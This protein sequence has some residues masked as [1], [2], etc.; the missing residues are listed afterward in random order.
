MPTAAGLKEFL[1][2]MD[3]EPH[4][5]LHHALAVCLKGSETSADIEL[6]A[7]ASACT[8]DQTQARARDAGVLCA[9][10]DLFSMGM[11]LMDEGLNPSVAL[12][13]PQDHREIVARMAQLADARRQ[14]QGSCEST[15]LEAGC[16]PGLRADD[17]AGPNRMT[18]KELGIETFEA[19]AP[20][21]SAERALS[22][23][24]P[25]KSESA[26]QRRPTPPQTQPS[27]DPGEHKSWETLRL[28]GNTAA[29]TLE[30][31]SHRRAGNFLGVGVVSIESARATKEGFDWSNKLTFQLTPEEMPEIIAVL[32][33]IRQKATF[34]NHGTDRNKGLS[35]RNQD[36][37]LQVV[38]TWRGDVYP[39]PVKRPVMYYLLDLF[40]RAMAHGNPDRKASDVIALV[41]GIYS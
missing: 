6:V 26:R 41:R 27:S 7:W 24:A 29:H 9:P 32:L 10:H 20:K 40:C 15:S 18:A 35:F 5:R 25:A 21:T 38:A 1:D 30:V 16:Q 28:F 34:N 2:R 33:G 3:A 13:R 17:S 36:D 19:A 22:D 8:G 39:I 31:S 11:S 12:L 4:Q 37:G 23:N 14:L